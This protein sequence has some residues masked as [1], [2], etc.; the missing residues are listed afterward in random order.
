MNNNGEQSSGVSFSVLKNLENPISNTNTL[1]KDIENSYFKADQASSIY[2]ISSTSGRISTL[3]NSFEAIK[4][5]SIPYPDKDEIPE[6]KIK[7]E[8]TLENGE[9]IIFYNNSN[10]YDNKFNKCKKCK[11][12]TNKFFCELCQINICDICYKDCFDKNH[13]LI[14]L[15]DKKSEAENNIKKISKIMF[16]NIIEPEKKEK[17]DS[18]IEK[19]ETTYVIIDEYKINNET[20][21]SVLDYTNDILLIDYI[22][23]KNYNNYF[24]Y[25]NIQECYD[26]LIKK[27]EVDKNED[28][29][30]ILVNFEEEELNNSILIKYKINNDENY[31]KLF[32]FL[33]VKNNKN[34]CSTIFNNKKYKLSVYFNLEKY[35]F[36]NNI[37]EIKLTGINNI[38]NASYMF[39]GCSSLIALSGI[40]D[41]DTTN[42]TDISGMFAGCSS[43][44]YLPNISKWNTSNISNMSSLFENCSS[45][46]SLPD[47]SNWKTTNVMNISGIFENCSSLESLPDISKWDISNVVKKNY[48]FYGCPSSL[49]FPQKFTDEVNAENNNIIEE[50]SES[51]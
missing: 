49:E 32:G 8:N 4:E 35:K 41:W 36:K 47:I 51:I 38:Q 21:K 29:E 12:N 3:K 30:Y 17:K 31:I 15:K 1:Q 33:F 50:K 9:K 19:K 7:D 46:K 43:L 16:K 42:I 28:K 23:E 6:I 5:N 14:N 18:G 37:L 44:E 20:E 13:G 26:Y 22:I 25:K 27:Y 11:N 48:M 10:L 39:R 2:I 40:S 45:L 24:H 34:K